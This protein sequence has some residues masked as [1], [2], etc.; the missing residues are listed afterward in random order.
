GIGGGIAAGIGSAEGKGS[1]IRSV[2][3]C[4]GI[5]SVNGRTDID[6]EGTKQI[7][8]TQR[9]IRKALAH[10]GSGRDNGSE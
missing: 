3:Y 4:S 10:A 9:R 5:M 2:G 7:A 8:D 1:T 6:N